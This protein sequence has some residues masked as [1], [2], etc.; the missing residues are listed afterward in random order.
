MMADFKT[1]MAADANAAR[2]DAEHLASLATV[3]Q[4]FGDVRSC[5]EL[6]AMLHGHTVSR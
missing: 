5:D 2:S 1:F 6:I 3:I 4:F